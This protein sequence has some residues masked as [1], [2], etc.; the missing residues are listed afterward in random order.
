MARRSRR[1]PSRTPTAAMSR[2]RARSWPRPPRRIGARTSSTA[3]RAAMSCPSS[4][5][6]A[7]GG[8]RRCARQRKSSN[9]SGGGAERGGGAR[10]RRPRP[11]RSSPIRSG[12][13]PAP[14]VG[15]PGCA[16]GAGRSR[17]SAQARR[18]RSHAH[19]PRDSRSRR[20]GSRRSFRSSARQTRPTRPGAARGVAA[21][22]T[23]RMAPGTT[24]PYR[25][26]GAAGG[27][28]QHHRPRLAAGQDGRPAG[29]PGLQRAGGGQ[30]APDRGR[31]RGDGRLARLRPPRADG[32]RHRARA[33]ARRRRS[34]PGL[35]SPTPA[36]GTSAR[37]RTSLTAASRC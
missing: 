23:R 24:K 7:R 21:D 9:A 14:M 33:R 32:R 30:R 25:A 8:A 17:S 6:R 18:G 1:T 29:D 11:W 31:R 5:A 26:A 19:A 16:R 3:R 4:F 12:L 13:S 10:P 35:S 27:D 2:S 34:R 36:T 37:W 15:A 22:G 28:D 20:A